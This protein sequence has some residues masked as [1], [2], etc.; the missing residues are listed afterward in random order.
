V[1]RQRLLIA[2][3]KE[4]EMRLNSEGETEETPALPLA[5]DDAVPSQY[6]LQVDEYFRELSRAPST[7]VVAD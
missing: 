6:R 3:L 2:R 5:G 7:G 4:L 1:Q